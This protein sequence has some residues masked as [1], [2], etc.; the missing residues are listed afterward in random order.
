[1]RLAASDQEAQRAVA[2]IYGCFRAVVESA[3]VDT[4]LGEVVVGLLRDAESADMAHGAGATVLL[5]L[6]ACEAAGAAWENAVPAATC[7]RG[8]DM[9]AKVLDDAQDGDVG[10]ATD[11][12]GVAAIVNVAPVYYALSMMCLARLDGPI[13]ADLAGR[14]Q[15][16]ILRMAAGQHLGLL[17]RDGGSVEVGLRSIAEKTGSYFGLAAVLGARCATN[18]PAALAA[19][20]GFGTNAGIVLQLLDDLVDLRTQGPGGD[21]ADGR[22][23]LPILY[24]LA[25]V[26]A[27][28][29]TGL[30]ALLDRA[31]E[32][33]AAEVRARE[34]VMRLGAESYLRAEVLRYRMRAL[35]AGRGYAER[36]LAEWLSD[37]E[38][39]TLN[40]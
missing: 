1:M 23:T 36:G 4:G 39:G 32:D 28:Q 24:A 16:T 15:S 7:W 10:R 40:R 18:D 17:M 29:R 2:T 27:T 9:A 34:W 6:L 26:P 5:P 35:E 31:R 25:V 37:L 11:P 21:L 14:M 30:Q 8:L 12:R 19:L 3:N 33:S 13:Y 22:R 20:E 38:E